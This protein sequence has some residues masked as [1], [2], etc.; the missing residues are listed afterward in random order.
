M[1]GTG[2][3]WSGEKCR[4]VGVRVSFSGF[5]PVWECFSVG[6][7]R[8]YSCALHQ[9]VSQTSRPVEANLRWGGGRRGGVGSEPARVGK[10]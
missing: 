9:R 6:E 7:T 3:V 8:H 4:Y 1:A 10:A 5:R 2:R